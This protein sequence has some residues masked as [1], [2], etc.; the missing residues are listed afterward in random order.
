MSSFWKP[1]SRSAAQDAFQDDAGE[2]GF[3][4]QAAFFS[5]AHNRPLA[6][7]RMLLPIYKHKKQILYAAEQYSVVVIVGETGSGKST[8]IPQYLV[9]AGGWADNDFSVVV[10]Q[11]RRLAAMTLAQRVAQEV[12]TQVRFDD[13]SSPYTK[14]K[15]VTDGM[16]LREATLSDPLL[17]NYSVVMVDEAHER[18]LNSDAVL[19]LLKKIRRKRKNNLRIIVCSATIDAPAFLNFFLNSKTESVGPGS[20]NQ[21]HSRWEP[22][23]SSLYQSA[24]LDEPY[25]RGTIISVDGRQFSVDILYLEQPAPDY[26]RQTVHTV[27][28]ICHTERKGGDIL[29]FFPSGENIDS[30]I[31]LAEEELE[32][33]HNESLRLL[34]DFLPLYGTLPFHMQARVFQPPSSSDRQ[35]KQLRRVIFATNIAETSV[36]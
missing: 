31:R 27:F 22:S 11:P 35:K 20:S 36:T 13:Q 17:S 12:N 5:P 10:T 24:E 4:S 23:T 33:A 7:Q 30:A 14:I 19:G 3:V 25:N 6:Q 34:L 18:N 26:I 32:Q 21:T 16:L 1:D 29:C 28:Q 2:N 15:Y 9:E 8:Q